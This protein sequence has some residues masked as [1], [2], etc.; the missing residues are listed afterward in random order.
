L[1]YEVSRT[2]YGAGLRISGA[3]VRSLFAQ[4]EQQATARLGSWFDGPV[5]LERSAEMRYGEQIFEIDVALDDL[6]W[7]GRELVDLIEDRFHRRH[8]QLY[9]YSLRDQEVVFVNA[10]VAAVGKVASRSR[11]A[12]AAQRSSV[13]TPRTTRPAFFGEWCDI[14]V[15]DLERLVSGQTLNGAAIIEA[16]TTTVLLHAG[17]RA[18]VNALGWL[19]I[20][21][22][23]TSGG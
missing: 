5:T 1:R 18:T 2:H 21:V 17:D 11:T 6:D 14:P 12:T 4:L 13:A 19:E 23:C 16:E 15:Y 7:D 10:R 9:T 20:E 3:A 22:A 8:E